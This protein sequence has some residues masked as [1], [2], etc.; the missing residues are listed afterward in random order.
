VWAGLLGER[1]PQQD[2]DDSL[3]NW[4]MY[5]LA[6]SD[7]KSPCKAEVASSMEDLSVLFGDAGKS[8]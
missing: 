7:L 8:R 4:I 1:P 2:D 3:D 5:V 6:V